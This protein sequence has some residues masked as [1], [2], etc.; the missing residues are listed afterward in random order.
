MNWIKKT[1][2]LKYEPG[3]Y[4]KKQGAI[5]CVVGSAYY[6]KLEDMGYTCVVA[7]N[8]AQAMAK[9]ESITN[10]NY[11]FVHHHSIACIS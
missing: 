1:F 8:I 4:A 9:I 7:E 3:E 6:V 10:A 11:E 5:S 2:G